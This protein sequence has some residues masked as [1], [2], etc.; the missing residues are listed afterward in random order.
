ME[1]QDIIY[2]K[3]GHVA[4][5]TLN[6]PERMNAFTTAMIDSIAGA[7]EDADGDEG[8]R[9]IV[10]TGAG[11]AFSAGLDLKEPPDFLGTQGSGVRMQMLRMFRL[12]PIAVGIDKPIVACINGPAIGWGLEL[13]LLCDIRVAVDN[14][15][16]GDR[17]IN[18]SLLPDF[19]GLFHLPRLVGWAKACELFFTG[20]FVDGTE[21]ERIGLVNKAVTQEQLDLCV[22]EIV[23]ALTKQPPIALQAAKRAMRN[24]LTGD[25]T[26][27]QDYVLTLQGALVATEDFGE[28]MTA[29]MERRQ[30]QFK[31]H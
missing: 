7:F 13:A 1:Y 15:Q 19:A 14:A 25:L 9:A 3:E 2:T 23:Q 12:P 31:G 24:A 4:T 5:V 21:A 17:H 30:S 16:I 20:Q 11:R 8:I 18:Y 22:Q 29:L 28:A 6:R 10:V 27:S 26:T